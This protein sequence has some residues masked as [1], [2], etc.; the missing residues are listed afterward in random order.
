[1]PIFEASHPYFEEALEYQILMVG[2]AS[3]MPLRTAHQTITE[4]AD[5]VNR[6]NADRNAN[7]EGNV[8][9]PEVT[10]KMTFAQGRI[11]DIIT[12]YNCDKMFK[13][14]SGQASKPVRIRYSVRKNRLSPNV[15]EHRRRAAG[16]PPPSPW[17]DSRYGGRSNVVIS[18][19]HCKFDRRG[20]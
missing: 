20:L 6:L 18:A 1:M 13:F 14:V 10:S 4:L 8:T 7:V 15:P 17:S 3:T 5:V 11:S 2:L 16:R 12:L 9:M 19:C